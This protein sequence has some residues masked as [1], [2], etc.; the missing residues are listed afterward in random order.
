MANPLLVLR[1][2][3]QPNEKDGA[4]YEW[5]LDGVY[6]GGTNPGLPDLLSA[7]TGRKSRQESNVYQSVFIS[8]V[9]TMRM[10]MSRLVDNQKEE[11][12]L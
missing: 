7:H 5:R 1:F 2:F 8:E 10:A 11:L 3:T 12:N 4:V 9:W 6:K